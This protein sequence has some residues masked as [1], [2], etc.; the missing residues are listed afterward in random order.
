M[1]VNCFTSARLI[2]ETDAS[3]RGIRDDPGMHRLARWRIAPVVDVLLPWLVGF[4]LVL[5]VVD[6]RATPT[7]WP[8]LLLGVALALVQAGALRWR[9]RRPE[10]V[11]AIAI[12]GGLALQP[13]APEQVIPVAALCAVGSLAAARPPRVSL[14]GLLALLALV[15][16]DLFTTTVDDT[17]FTMGLAVG[18]W[19][20]GEA[21]RN[22][23]AAL[24][25]EARGRCA[26]SRHASR[27][28][29]T[30]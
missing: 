10:L 23:R 28:S 26:R 20:L 24:S 22:R 3:A 29:C 16:T 7:D 4:F 21:A 1:N 2:L 14:V 8:L 18:A 25:E 17:V 5:V 27:A 13:I 9:R 15:A 6:E 11:T 30:T 12:C 19:A